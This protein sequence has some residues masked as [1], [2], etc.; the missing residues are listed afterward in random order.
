MKI[1]LPIVKIC[2][3]LSIYT[4]GNQLIASSHN[5]IA[6]FLQPYP[7][8][9]TPQQSES[10]VSEGLSQPGY[11]QAKMASHRFADIATEGVFALYQGYVTVSSRKGE[12]IFPRKQPDSTIN[13]LITPEVIPAFI[14]APATTHHWEL[15]PKVST[16]KNTQAMYSI[17][18]THDEETDAYFYNVK[19]IP[20]PADNIIDFTTV[21]LLAPAN[22]IYVPEGISMAQYSPN[23]IVPPIYVKPG[24]QFIDHALYTLKIKQYFETISKQFNKYSG[25]DQNPLYTVAMVLGNE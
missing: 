4:I 24:I 5:D 14:V 12:I 20:L 25:T 8:V 11:V 18:L 21:V 22:M 1:K 3:A 23:I 7:E 2:I 17:T 16:D 19:S 6:L 13:V 10:T 9:Q 15:N